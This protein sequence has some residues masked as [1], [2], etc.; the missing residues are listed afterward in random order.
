MSV[1]VKKID[2]NTWSMEEPGVRFF[3]LAGEKKALLIDSGMQM[4][5][6]KELAGELTDLPIE[7]I[8]THADPDHV[9]SN[10]EF[11]WFYMN[12]AEG[13]N[14]Y[15]TFKR[16][17]RIVPVWEGSEIDLGGRA[18]RVV[19]IPGHTPGSIAVIDVNNRRV[20]SGDT[21][22]DGRIF[23]FGVQ[24]EMHAFRHSL[25]K[26]DSFKNMF[27]KVYPC[28]GTCPVDPDLIMKLYD[29]AGDVMEGRVEGRPEE[30][31][32]TPVAVYDVGTATFLCD[33]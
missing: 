33:L 22:Q 17:G 30:L 5:N 3:L 28:H 12:P 15:N 26:L 14:F 25:I 2:E 10:D 16:T 13:S 18:L 20:F 24:R 1:E 8:N 11:E 19:E 21:V 23:M 9:G 27:D 32:G 29:A 6:A 7:L 4:R 31:R